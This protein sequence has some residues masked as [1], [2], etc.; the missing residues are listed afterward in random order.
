MNRADKE[1]VVEELRSKLIESDVAVFTRFTGLKVSELG[2]LRRG[3]KKISVDYH[4]V[5][6]TL[7]RRA[8]EGTDV[9][10]LKDHIRGPLAVAM[11]KGDIVPLAKALTEYIKDHPKLEIEVGVAGGRVLVAD[12]IQKAAT[13]PAREELVAKLMFLLQAPVGRLLS[14]MK[15]IPAKLVRTLD[16]IR[17]LKESQGETTVS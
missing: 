13:L 5:K 11:G 9:V 15:E 10:L 3:L 17:K 1:R 7:L 4:V 6:N 14:V 8:M 16:E 2:E 12:E